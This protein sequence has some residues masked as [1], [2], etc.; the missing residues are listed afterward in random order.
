MFW[1]EARR[2]EQVDVAAG[3][4]QLRADPGLVHDDL[5]RELLDLVSGAPRFRHP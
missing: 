3:K 5:R 1:K 2:G 4:A